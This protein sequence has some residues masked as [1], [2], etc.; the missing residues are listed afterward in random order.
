MSSD[1]QKTN[2]ADNNRD[3][4]PAGGRRICEVGGR[5]M[6]YTTT[7]DLAGALEELRRRYGLGPNV[8]VPYIVNNHTRMRQLS[9][10]PPPFPIGFSEFEAEVRADQDEVEKMTPCG[11]CLTPGHKVR[12]CV[13][14]ADDGFIHGCPV[15]NT[16]DHESADGCHVPWPKQLEKKLSWAIERR[17]HRPTLAGFA[18]WVDLFIEA[19]EKG[20]VAL[21]QNF[22][23]TPRFCKS[24]MGHQTQP[25]TDFDYA[26]NNWSDLPKDPERADQETVMENQAWLRDIPSWVDC[27]RGGNP[28]APLKWEPIDDDVDEPEGGIDDE[29]SYHNI[30]KD[31]VVEDDIYMP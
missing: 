2:A 5:F 9:V 7:E 28:W 23:W 31:D 26:K 3:K 27:I 16:A 30:V 6:A 17:A 8:Q 15:C 20:D 10:T 13:H 14:P 11:N 12:N 21:P 22:P 18:N 25:W 29:M 19:K 4:Q 24:L 1:K